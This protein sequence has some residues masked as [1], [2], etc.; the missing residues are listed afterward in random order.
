MTM[1]LTGPSARFGTCLTAVAKARGVHATDQH[2][3]PDRTSHWS[4]DGPS[5]LPHSSNTSR[6]LE[7]LPVVAPAE[8]QGQVM[9]VVFA[10]EVGAGPVEAGA[11]AE[12]VEP[13]VPVEQVELEVPVVL[14]QRVVWPDLLGG[15]YHTLCNTIAGTW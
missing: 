1:V 12:G 5:W 11:L 9:V 10:L 13:E 15:Q 14:D 7:G 4:L 2:R 3:R 6:G 8:R